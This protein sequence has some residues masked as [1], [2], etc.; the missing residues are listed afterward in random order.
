MLRSKWLNLVLA[1]LLAAAPLQGVFA[2]PPAHAAMAHAANGGA[3]NAAH[4]AGHE[5]VAAAP[6]Q[7]QQP[8]QSCAQ[9]KGPCPA[10]SLCGAHC[11]APLMHYELSSLSGHCAVTVVP[12]LLA[13]ILAPPPPGEPP[14][15]LRS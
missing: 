3:P 5:Q 1:C 12:P 4:R 14:R 10:C 11:A 9:H 13:A 2:Q 8:D 6:A 15:T 7:Q